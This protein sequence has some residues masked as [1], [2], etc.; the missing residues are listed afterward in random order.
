[1]VDNLGNLIRHTVDKNN[2]MKVH[3]CQVVLYL[4]HKE[5]Q[6]KS[7]DFNDDFA[8]CGETNGIPVIDTVPTFTLRTGDLDDFFLFMTETNSYATHNRLGVLKL[9]R[10]INR[11]CPQFK[12]CRNW[13]E[14]RI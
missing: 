10:T 1:M 7:E 3:V 4:T 9:L 8:K 14:V 5:T 6:E 13:E 11:Q 2:T 12:L